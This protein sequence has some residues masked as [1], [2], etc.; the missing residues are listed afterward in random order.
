MIIKARN[1]L[2]NNAP[3]T[4]LTANLASGTT[5]ISVKNINGMTNGWAVQFGDTGEERTEIKV[6]NSTPS[7]GTFGLSA[8]LSYN[9][10]SDTPV[11]AIKY[12]QMIFKR[13]TAG[14]AGTASSLTG[15][16]VTIQADSDYTQFDDTSGS[17]TYA[18]RASYYSTGLSSESSNSDWLT[19]TGYAFF[20][21]AKLRER[22]KGKL[23]SAGYLNADDS[24]V[25]D[26]I[27]EWMETMNNS[28]ISVDKDYGIGTVN[29]TYG[30]SGLGTISSSDFQEVKR[31]W[32]T[33]DGVNNYR[34][35][36]MSLNDFDPNETFN[37]THPYYYYVGDSVFGVK[38][39][40]SGGTAQLHYYKMRTVLS[41]DTD[42]LPVVMQAYTSSFINYCVA[43]AYYND[44]KE[45]MGD[46][47]LSR[48]ESQK[49]EFINMITPR[50][51][52]GIVM[53]S[54]TDPIDSDDGTWEAR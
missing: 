34:A 9:H 43:E 33:T 29:V 24:Q 53:M 32:I 48:A 31:M 46:R 42:E 50:N 3:K 11:Y 15:G 28:A 25:N 5:T 51:K 14:T 35:T 30:T 26:W 1:L 39:E 2:Q 44:G 38:P 16:T 20:S 22:A 37:S 54:I 10:P 40:G 13:S 47:Y 45:S 27:N 49:D 41:N 4:F 52:T 12:D 8:G 19:P 6:I 18:Y 7:A 17:T 21:L 23:F 36:K